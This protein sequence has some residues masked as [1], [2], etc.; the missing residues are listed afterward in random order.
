MSQSPFSEYVY[1][2]RYARY[3]HEERRREKWP[4][5]VKR[6]FDF[7]VTHLKNECQYDL[8]FYSRTILENSI[9][10]YDVMPSMRCLMTAGVALERENIGGFNCLYLAV[11][12]PKAFGE[13]LYV[14]MNGCGVGFS[15]E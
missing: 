9:L 3:L 1:V 4:E 15:I 6:Y 8:D 7:F 13:M 11:D 2:S 14:L 10:G 12:N 5:T